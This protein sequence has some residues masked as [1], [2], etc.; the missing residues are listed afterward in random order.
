MSLEVVPE[1]VAEIYLE[2]N[3]D[4]NRGNDIKN[5]LR[6]AQAIQAQRVQGG[7]AIRKM[8]EIAQSIY[9]ST[10][11]I[12]EEVPRHTSKIL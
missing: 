1:T 5:E 2:P 4:K 6:E 8:Q 3:D 7:A 12:V 10:P 9:D 11:G